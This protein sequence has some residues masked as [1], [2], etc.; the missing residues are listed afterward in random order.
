MGPALA[1]QRGRLL[2]LT[3]IGFVV[4]FGITCLIVRAH[5]GENVLDTFGFRLVAGN[6]QDASAAH[7]AELGTTAALVIG[8]IGAGVLAFVLRDP[9]RAAACLLGPFVATVIAQWVAK[10]A[11]GRLFEDVLTFPSGS[12]TVVAALATAWTLAV[13]RRAQLPVGVL[14]AVLTSAELWA[15]VRLRW[16][17]PSDGLGAILLAV[18]VLL[19][20]AGAADLLGTGRLRPHQQ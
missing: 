11:V 4:L 1:Q 10:P 6:G 8:S 7:V 5:P 13:G 9:L 12:V 14:G 15:V 17:E 18:G 19:T 3:G 16:H 20:L 2:L